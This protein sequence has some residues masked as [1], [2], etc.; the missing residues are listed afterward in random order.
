MIT[1]LF[2]EKSQSVIITTADK[3]VQMPTESLTYFINQKPVT[4]EIRSV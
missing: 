4:V 2:D 1:I 3:V